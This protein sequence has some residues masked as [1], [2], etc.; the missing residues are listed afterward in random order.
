MSKKSNDQG[1]GKVISIEQQ[2]PPPPKIK[3]LDLYTALAGAI[4]GH[5]V[6]NAR[7]AFASKFHVHKDFMGISQISEEKPDQVLQYVDKKKVRDCLTKY[8]LNNAGAPLFQ[9]V[10]PQD[11]PKIAEFWDSL[12]DPFPHEIAPVRLKSEPGFTWHRLPF[13]LQGG[14]YPVWSELLSR[15]SNAKAFMQ[16]VGSLL[17]PFS[18]RQQYV[19]F[20]GGGRN[21]KGSI[22]RFLSKLI[23]PATTWEQVPDRQDRFWT[24][25]LLGKRLVIFG[26]C[27]NY[28]FP[29]TGLFKS[30]TGD[31]PCRIERKNQQPFTAKMGCKFL[32]LSNEKPTLS[33]QS[34]D[35]RRAIFCE[36]GAVQTDFGSAYET[37]LWKEAPYFVQACYELYR[38]AN[39][40]PISVDQEELEL[41]ASSSEE[42]Y[43]VIWHR[44]FVATNDEDLEMKDRAYIH[45]MKMRDILKFEGLSHNHSVTKFYQ[46]AE[47]MHGMKRTRVRVGETSREYRYIGAREQDHK[48]RE[49]SLC[50][51]KDYNDSK[52]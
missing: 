51:Y 46:W 47:R 5:P 8:I 20:Y 22:G 4:Q 36:I 12:S 29:T 32:F 49:A 44:N 15:M 48:E 39:G 24:S 11:I 28:G 40:A 25:G 23:G 45:P 17:D 21:G 38:K 26:D 30:L 35:L 2:L 18:D 27:N 19:W 37:Q 9:Q 41:L 16:W 33:S 3:R 31:D 34:A 43:E 14:P 6:P 42:P 10:D 52:R 7:F 13:D 50:V 1:N